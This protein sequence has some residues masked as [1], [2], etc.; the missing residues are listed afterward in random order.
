MTHATTS[1]AAAHSK[2]RK[3]VR[4]RPPAG[5]KP[6][7]EATFTPPTAPDGPTTL[8][9][10]ERQQTI[11]ERAY[12]RAEQRGF[13]PGRELEDWLAAEDEVNSICSLMSRDP[14]Y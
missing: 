12:Y 5:T 14:C 3:K 4:A 11:A 9:A 10:P 2:P 13:A 1:H 6:A 8:N 7:D